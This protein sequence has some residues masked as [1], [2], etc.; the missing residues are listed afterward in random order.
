M[1]FDPV[2][3]AL[4]ER[5]VE[6]AFGV[7]FKRHT[8][9]NV[10]CPF[11]EE[12]E[13]S[14]TQSCSVSRIGV[15]TCH[16]CGAKGKFQDFYSQRT[17]VAP[18]LV[19]EQLKQLAQSDIAQ[20]GPRKSYSPKSVNKGLRPT[21]AQECHE[22]LARNDKWVDYLKRERGLTWATI[23]R[24]LI[25]CDESRI[26]IPIWNQDHELVN[27]RRYL[28]EKWR[29]AQPKMV[30][31]A[32]GDGTP[33]L[34]DWQTLEDLEYGSELIVCEGE[35]DKLLLEQNGFPAI[36]NTGN[37]KTWSSEWTDLLFRYRLVFMYDVNDKYVVGEGTDRLGERMARARA[38][39]LRQAGC[40][41]VRV[42]DLPL[43]TKYVGGDVTNWF[44][45]E[46]HTAKEL[47]ELIDGTSE[48]AESTKVIVDMSTPASDSSTTPPASS[49]QTA[50]GIPS[51]DPP[52]AAPLPP[53][54]KPKMQV[55]PFRMEQNAPLVTLTQATDAK[56]FHKPIRL[57]CLVAG[58]D[59]APFFAPKKVEIVTTD[60]NGVSETHYMEFGPWDGVILS[61]IKVSQVAQKRVICNLADIPPENKTFITVQ[62]TMNV[63][64]VLLIPAVDA[65]DKEQGPYTL[66]T[67]YFIGQNL[68][69]NRVYDFHGYTLP[70]P[71]T[72]QAT[73]ILVSARPAETSLDNF[74]MTPK[75][76]E[77]LKATFQ[78][79]D[80][81]SVY[82]KFND[83]ADQMARHVTHI[84][85]RTDLHTAIDLVF[86]SPLSFD[87][88]G[89]RVKKGWLEC[90]VLG[91]TRTGKGFVTE[92]L[93]KHYR[94]GE[95]I[96]GEN[97]SIAGIV[98]GIQPVGDRWTLVW[99]KIPLSDR[100]L[101]VMDECGSLSYE[102]IGRLSRIR[103]EGVAEITKII[104]EKT[105]ART[106]MIWLA[107]PRPTQGM[108]PRVISD[109]SF[110]VEAVPE[111]IGA[112]EDVARFDYVLIVARNEVPADL[113]NVRQEPD[114]EN[115][116]SSDICNELVLW[117][118]S[119]KPDQIVFAPGVV[120]L[121]LR[122]AK[123]L[124][125]TFS[126]KICLIQGE[127]VRYKLARI[128]CAAAARMFSTT[129]G[130]VLMVR[131]EHMQFAYNFLHHIYGKA[132]CGYL[133]FS[134][135]EAERS[136][137]KNTAELARAL[138]LA[139]PNMVDLV[140]GM[141]ANRCLTL[142][143][144]MDYSGME[145]PQAR[146]MLSEL[147]RLRAITKDNNY[148]LKTPAFILYLQQVQ[149][150]LADQQKQQ[151]E[152]SQI[153]ATGS[154]EDGVGEVTG[155][156][157]GTG[158]QHTHDRTSAGGTHETFWPHA[159]SV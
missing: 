9:L 91:D 49:E 61:L 73:H 138:Q 4:Y 92:G 142:G 152:S 114:S 22:L 113:I 116:Y 47:R 48:Y 136:T 74:T 57:R 154:D 43:P 145:A 139:G 81:E 56:Y 125:R 100:R 19:E 40:Q 32:M 135:Q 105:R 159:G 129:D 67:A 63:E 64:E 13:S 99:G 26:T 141:I 107:N 117:A 18:D 101:V 148:Y 36:T 134:A 157:N 28:P 58:K 143:H 120:D 77:E 89:I 50:E 10:F 17:G 33:T 14:R 88:D 137:I 75:R 78:P 24:R 79:R 108:L 106:R 133:R 30:T 140:D 149:M 87:F 102:S 41:S 121:A 31:H 122:G 21:L 71:V 25:G 127:D 39:E 112:A 20:T 11:H 124:G 16:S 44:V 147:V 23:Q 111:L 46:R 12:P 59:T 126:S 156:E 119:R 153:I 2:Q 85:G 1:L 76:Y 86:H 60:K 98:G 115:P 5:M 54:I 7:E 72:Q 158:G 65:S 51:A 27:I 123:H 132:S 52:T 144:L 45:H 84:Q 131:E 118:W 110:G 150:S 55:A 3:N 8:D 62:E 96:S 70:N 93:T 29:G 37:C 94:L 80:G 97:L 128:A 151:E 42:V 38:A 146:V 103:S 82:A 83:I 109:Y 130:E 95:V 68:E 90:L 53:P 104:T 35:F 66:R 6:I 15:F 69:P 155:S 34:Y